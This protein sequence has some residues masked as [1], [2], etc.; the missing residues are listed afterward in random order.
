MPSLERVLTT[1]GMRGRESTAE[2]ARLPGQGS[3]RLRAAA[4]AR[5][6]QFRHGDAALSGFTD[7][8]LGSGGAPATAPPG[9]HFRWERPRRSNVPYRW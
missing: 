5:A 1:T 6:F 9:G 2:S 3:G 7:A 8:A 4:L